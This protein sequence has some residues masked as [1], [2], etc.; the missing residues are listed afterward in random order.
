MAWG[1]RI[2]QESLQLWQLG[3]FHLA[4]EV[5]LTAIARKYTFDLHPQS[6]FR[7]TL[8]ELRPFLVGNFKSG[9]DPEI[10]WR[11]R[12]LRDVLS[13]LFQTLIAL[14]K[15]GLTGNLVPRRSYG[16]VTLGTR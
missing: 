4:V 6:N 16:S 15:I 8:F 12:R 11:K 10:R 2:N 7:I 14:R 3:I 9:H 1:L 13:Q 5:L